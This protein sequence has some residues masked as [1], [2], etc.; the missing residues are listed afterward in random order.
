MTLAPTVP[1]IA[2][3]ARIKALP[4]KPAAGAFCTSSWAQAA[5][6]IKVKKFN[7]I[8]RVKYRTYAS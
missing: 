4:D 1:I 5:E 6:V 7:N 2:A 8:A 3:I